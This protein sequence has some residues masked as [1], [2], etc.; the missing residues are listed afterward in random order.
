MAEVTLYMTRARAVVLYNTVRA[1]LVPGEF[2]PNSPEQLEE[3]QEV[4]QTLYEK[5]Q[6]GSR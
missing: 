1:W 5:L 6:K 3:L 4:V 2:G